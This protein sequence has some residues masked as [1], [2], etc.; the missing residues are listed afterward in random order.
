MN[1]VGSPLKE[2]EDIVYLFA[3]MFDFE[4]QPVLPKYENENCPPS[5]PKL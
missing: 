5:A 2:L 4:H 1:G 3:N